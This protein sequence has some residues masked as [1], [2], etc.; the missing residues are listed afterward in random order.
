M[1]ADTEELLASAE[2]CYA[3]YRPG[4]PIGSTAVVVAQLPGH[5]EW[6]QADSARYRRNRAGCATSGR[7]A[8]GT[9]PGGASPATFSAYRRRAPRMW[10]FRIR[11]HASGWRR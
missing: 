10:T 8:R 6:R 4:Y 7:Q 2:S 11:R 5:I 9:W 3:R 1:T